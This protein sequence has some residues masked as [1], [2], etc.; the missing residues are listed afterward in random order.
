MQTDTLLIFVKNPVLGQVKT[1][2]ARTLGDERALQI[3]RR[4]LAH[5]L[6][7]T[8]PLPCRKLVFYAD[9][10]A[11]GDLWA[12]AGYEQNLQADG[13]LGQRMHAA[14]Q[15]AFAAA[16][17]RVVV[18]GSDCWELTTAHL[19]EAFQRL[20]TH[21]AVIGPAHDGGYYL[22]GLQRAIPALFAHKAW[23]TAHVLPDTLADLTRLQLRY[24]LLPALS[25]VDE[26]ADLPPELRF[27]PGVD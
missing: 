4:L 23:S 5:T 22:L 7:I 17:P 13:D 25:D 14:F 11:P 16:A 12:Q 8:A 21:E 6:A 24:A 9:Y 18:I 26:A 1:R 27:S 19:E 3:Y 15:T 2:L 10:I 20:R